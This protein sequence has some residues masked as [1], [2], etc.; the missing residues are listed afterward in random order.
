V[1]QI[2]LLYFEDLSPL[3]E[4]VFAFPIIG[5]I[6]MRQMLIIGLCAVI[7]WIT[8]QSTESILSA[9]PMIAGG[10]VGLRRFNVKPPESELAA[11]IKFVFKNSG[12]S[13]KQRRK[14]KSSKKLK[15]SEMYEPKGQANR[16]EVRTRRIFADPLKPLRLQVKLETPTKEL[17]ANTRVRVEFDG[18]VISTPS[19][20]NNGE[21]EILLIPQSLGAKKLSIFVESQTLPVFEEILLLERFQT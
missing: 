11:V 7:S 1:K 8:Y 4:A 19:T 20:N 5:R 12:I 6:S 10:Y 17:I 2:E 14:Q 3:H 16:E 13:N 15:A 9:M 21:I 18:N